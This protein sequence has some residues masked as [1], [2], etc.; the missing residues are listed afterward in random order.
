MG[1]ISAFIALVAMIFISTV[2]S[3]LAATI[4]EF[5]FQNYK[6][7]IWAKSGNVATFALENLLQRL[8]CISRYF[9]LNEFLH[10]AM[11]SKQIMTL[12]CTE[13]S[14]NHSTNLQ[15]SFL[16]VSNIVSNQDLLNLN[17]FYLEIPYIY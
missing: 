6:V 11:G 10:W 8:I 2:Y 3:M 14:T 5:C 1:I 13:Q 7:L 15:T 17:L 12:F 4:Y 16:P 9:E